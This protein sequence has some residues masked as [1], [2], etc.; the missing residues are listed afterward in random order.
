MSKA[1]H[2]YPLSIEVTSEAFS[3]KMTSEQLA[4]WLNHH[5]TQMIGTDYHVDVEKLKGNSWYVVQL[6][7]YITAYNLLS[8]K[9]NRF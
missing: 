2:T 8:G 4:V 9:D 5:I 6:H 1:K 7:K 3:D